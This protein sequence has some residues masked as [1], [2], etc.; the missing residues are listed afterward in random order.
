MVN[1]S[2]NDA[3]HADLAALT[4]ELASLRAE[5]GLLLR[6]LKLTRREAMPPGPAQAGL[7]DALSG[8]VHAASSLEAKVAF[9]SAMFAKVGTGL[10]REAIALRWRMDLSSHD[11]LFPSQDVL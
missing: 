4:A 9:F 8:I 11:R 3:D 5:T 7:F 10:L 6:L 2:R 1:A